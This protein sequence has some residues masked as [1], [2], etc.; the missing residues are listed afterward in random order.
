MC[1]NHD[2]FITLI[3]DKLVCSRKVIYREWVSIEY[4]CDMLGRF[5]ENFALLFDMEFPISDRKVDII[6]RVVDLENLTIGLLHYDVCHN[7]NPFAVR[8]R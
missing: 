8:L 6:E 2:Q 1:V 5:R 4:G 3:V 7:L